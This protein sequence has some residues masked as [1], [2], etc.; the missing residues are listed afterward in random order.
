MLTLT[1]GEGSM[2]EDSKDYVFTP[3]KDASGWLDSP[4]EAKEFV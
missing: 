2:E 4:A 1:D 3:L